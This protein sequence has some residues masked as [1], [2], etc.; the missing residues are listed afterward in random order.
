M[1]DLI[2]GLGVNAL[3]SAIQVLIVLI[4]GFVVLRLFSIASD[5]YKKRSAAGR[6]LIKAVDYTL[7]I[8]TVFMAVYSL[9]ASLT[10]AMLVNL[11][12]YMP[13]LVSTIL[14]LILG[15]MLVNLVMELVDLLFTSIKLQIYSKRLGVDESLIKILLL[16]LRLFLYLIVVQASLT[17]LGI[18]QSVVESSMSAI[19]YAFAFLLA[20]LVFFSSKELVKDWLAGF[21]LKSS[22]FLKMGQR[23]FVDDADGEVSGFSSFAT[24]LDTGKGYY[25]SVPHH[26]L[27]SN[28]VRLKKSR[29][30][31]KTLESMRRH[32]IAQEKSL[33]VPAVLN[34]I[35]DLFGYPT[36]GGQKAIA[37]EC[38]TVVPGGTT[39]ANALKAMG[40]LTENNV[41]GLLV[42]HKDILNLRDEVKAWLAE[43]ALV[44]LNFYKAALFPGVKRDQKHAVLCLG[45]E[46]ESLLI[47]D[48]NA[49]TGGVYVVNHKEMERAM[50]PFEGE[51]RSYIAYAPKGT[52]A[53]W[54][55]KN[56]L[57][58]SDPVHYKTLSKA[59]ERKM[60]QIFREATRAGEE[61]F[62][63]YVREFL[64]E[65]RSAESERIE[66]LWKP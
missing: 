66:R 53:F 5:E 41:Q 51:E 33:C 58:Y 6:V 57:Y 64:D 55:I 11:G 28:E 23:V 62:P 10:S 59:L 61:V 29:F 37:K 13:I 52:K 39:A 27:V 14:L 26:R 19:S 45:V 21:Y 16:G 32:Y 56:K 47:M 38:K 12:N 36:K 7:I 9:D 34:M 4:G 63:E 60:K 44:V 35:L 20:A 24:L 1:A 65:F 50:G 8:G 31:L 48:P 3:I 43:G 49:Q 40:A 18:P 30:E 22:R 54:R 2:P 42:P 25:L 46:G 17:Q 15:I